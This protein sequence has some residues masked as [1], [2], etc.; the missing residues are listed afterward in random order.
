MEIG[1][2]NLTCCSHGW[3]KIRNRVRKPYLSAG[4]RLILKQLSGHIVSSELM[5]ALHST[6]HFQ[7]INRRFEQIYAKSTS[8]RYES[9]KSSLIKQLNRKRPSVQIDALIR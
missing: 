9:I 6:S 3:L 1:E 4:N 5:F 8:C 7:H 2:G